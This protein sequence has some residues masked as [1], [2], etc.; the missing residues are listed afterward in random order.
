MEYENCMDEDFENM[1]NSQYP[2][3]KLSSLIR[4]VIELK[5]LAMNPKSTSLMRDKLYK[6]LSYLEEE[7]LL[8]TDINIP[9]ERDWFK[10]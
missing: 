2:E 3:V 9:L 4:S 6:R 1:K 10:E 8:L 5:V 7:L